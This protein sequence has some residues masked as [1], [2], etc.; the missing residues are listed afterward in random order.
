[1]MK[2]IAYVVDSKLPSKEA[3]SVHAVKMAK[4][5]SECCEVTMFC[6]ELLCAEDEAL[7]PYGIASSFDIVGANNRF[8][9]GKLKI[10]ID[11]W[12]TS[13][14]I[15]RKGSFDAIYG[16]S[17]TTLYFARNYA[18]FVFESH[19]WPTSKIMYFLQKE[20]LRS[21][22]CKGLVTITG[23]LKKQYLKTF[24]FLRDEDITVLQ[25]AADM[26]QK[27]PKPKE[28]DNTKSSAPDVVIGYLGHLYPGKCME[29]VSE[30]AA[31]RPNYLF[32][33]VG[34][35]NELVDYWKAELKQKNIRN[36]ILYG[37]VDNKE[38]GEWYSAFDIFL[39]PLKNN[40]MVGNGKKNIGKWISPLKLFEAMAYG[41]A[42]VSSDLPTLKEVIVD[43]QDALIVSANRAEEWADAID[44]LV[45]D[46]N[47]RKKL[48]VAAKKKLENYYT[49]SRR[50]REIVQIF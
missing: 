15:K 10:L 38:A 14:K 13:Q 47:L 48:G 27:Y 37:Y 9:S 41:K 22:N 4:A 44:Q 6:K 34:G 32:H 17:A 21:R 5:L 29:I 35:T 33:I 7:S 45:A 24:R 46:P 3:N 20:L 42:I 2:R 23:E 12:V 36:V 49:W 11:G 30:V 26:V 31:L 16:R 19:E 43:R 50:A 8:L 25:D 40:V 1:M 18:P 28:I 39:L